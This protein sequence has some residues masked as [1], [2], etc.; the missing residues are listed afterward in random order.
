VAE[1]DKEMRANSP[2]IALFPRRREAQGA[3]RVKENAASQ[4]LQKSAANQAGSV[5]VLSA[6]KSKA[7]PDGLL[8]GP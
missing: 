4:I 1:N 3:A 6:Q 7:K 5:T 2:E 8:R